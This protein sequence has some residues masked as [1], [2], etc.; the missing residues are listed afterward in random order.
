[1]IKKKIAFV[2]LF[3][4]LLASCGGNKKEEN[5]EIIK[6]LASA[7]GNCYFSEILFNEIMEDEIFLLGIHEETHFRVEVEGETTTAIF[8]DVYEKKETSSWEEEG[9]YFEGIC[10][11][12]YRDHRANKVLPV[13]FS[14]NPEDYRL[15]FKIGDKTYP[16]G[17]LVAHKSTKVILDFFLTKEMLQNGDG[18]S[19]ILEKDKKKSYLEVGFLGYHNCEGLGKEET[20]KI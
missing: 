15:R 2:F 20:G 16:L 17:K 12:K 9:A 18:L 14:K 6:M 5:D 3:C 19:L 4:F 11:A 8:S 7:A 1:M 13:K 10:F